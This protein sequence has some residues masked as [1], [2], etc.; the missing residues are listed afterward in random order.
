MIIVWGRKV[1]RRKAGYVADFCPCCRGLRP[2]MLY[3]HRSVAHIQRIPLGLV[4]AEIKQGTH[5][6]GKK[7]KAAEVMEQIRGTPEHSG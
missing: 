3:A 5:K 1:V 6:I 7:L 4:I 2:F